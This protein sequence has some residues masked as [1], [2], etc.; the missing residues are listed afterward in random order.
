MGMP[1]LR[2]HRHSHCFDKDK[3]IKQLN[4]V[5]VARWYLKEGDKTSPSRTETI[6]VGSGGSRT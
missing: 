5:P 3:V 1:V 2:L 4:I 6:S